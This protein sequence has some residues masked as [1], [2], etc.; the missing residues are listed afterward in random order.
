MTTDPCG[1]LGPEAAQYIDWAKGSQAHICTDGKSFY[2]L[3]AITI[4]K[5]GDSS[6]SEQGLNKRF[7]HTTP[8]IKDLYFEVLPGGSSTSLDGTQW[9]GL[10][11]DDLILSIYAGYKINGM[12]NGYTIPTTIDPSTLGSD[13]DIILG[14][15]V[16][17]AGLVSGSTCTDFG[18]VKAWAVGGFNGNLTDC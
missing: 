15:G 1:T 5:P 3:N 16:Q 6:C 10:K 2:L 11:I 4:N 12:K 13:G 8:A 18:K 14:S 9:G 7:C 17:T